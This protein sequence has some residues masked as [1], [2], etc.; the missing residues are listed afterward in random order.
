MKKTLFVA[1]FACF[2]ILSASC[3]PREPP[4]IPHDFK[5]SGSIQEVF[6]QSGIEC[7]MGACPTVTAFAVKTADDKTHMVALRGDR[8]AEVQPGA[9]IELVYNDLWLV[10]KRWLTITDEKGY[11]SDIQLFYQAVTQYKI[12]TPAPLAPIGNTPASNVGTT[13]KEVK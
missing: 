9:K 7:L 1:L 10:A 5:V 8:T 6:V 4:P 2:V 11:K 3:E 12:L 13:N